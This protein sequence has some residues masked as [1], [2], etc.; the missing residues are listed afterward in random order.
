MK[1]ILSKIMIYGV[2]LCA[3][4]S[5]AVVSAEEIKM[6]GTVSKITMAADKKSA[7]VILKDVKSGEEVS[8]TV[9]DELTLDKFNDKRIVDGDEIRCKYDNEGGKN[10]SKLFRKTAGC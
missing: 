2:L 1:R 8:I 10:I 4:L 7:V 9:E 3:L 5:A 6:I